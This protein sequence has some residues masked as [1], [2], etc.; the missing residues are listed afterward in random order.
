[1][2]RRRFNIRNLFRPRRPQHRPA[3]P[4]PPVP[5]DEISRKR[6]EISDTEGVIRHDHGKLTREEVTLRRL[7]AEL[8][9]LLARGRD[10]GGEQS[11]MFTALLGEVAKLRVEISGCSSNLNGI[12][13]RLNES[14]TK[15]RALNEQMQTLRGQYDTLRHEKAL[16]DAELQLRI[17]EIAKLNQTITELNAK[18][19]GLNG[20]I[21]NLNSIIDALN[22]QI[23]NLQQQKTFLQEQVFVNEITNTNQLLGVSEVIDGSLNRLFSYL[24]SSN[25]NPDVIYQKVNYRQIEHDKL[26]NI[27]KTLDVL[28]YCF[29]AAFVII[30]ICMGNTQKEKFLIYLIIGLVPVIYPFLFRFVNYL[31]GF[32]SSENHGPKNAFVDINNTIF[33]YNV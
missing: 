19:D 33:A 23:G 20:I 29:F 21:V 1:M 13:A 30:M 32:L 27:N 31:L 14:D 4:P 11:S 18:I 5:G 7:Q 15:L 2:G 12:R 26:Y 6:K 9:A 17:S 3:P 8:A 16:V 28:Y 24:K 25:I 10:V 22:T